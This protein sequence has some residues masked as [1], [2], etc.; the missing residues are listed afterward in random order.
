MKMLKFVVTKYV[1][2]KCGNIITVEGEC[3]EEKECY[4]CRGDVVYDHKG[5]EM[6]KVWE[7]NDG[8]V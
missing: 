5:K 4:A 8:K 1:C 6:K 3:H 2:P 7:K